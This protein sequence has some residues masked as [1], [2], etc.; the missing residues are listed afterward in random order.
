MNTVLNIHFWHL[1]LSYRRV[2]RDKKR[3]FSCLVLSRHTYL[4]LPPNSILIHSIPYMFQIISFANF[5]LIAY[6]CEITLTFIFDNILK[7][8]SHETLVSLK[9]LAPGT[10]SPDLDSENH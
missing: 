3:L 9:G 7:T 2:G 4:A 1:F 5:M 8:L 6:G 10:V